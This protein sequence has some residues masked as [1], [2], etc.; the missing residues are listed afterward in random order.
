MTAPRVE[1]EDATSQF[2]TAEV[3]LKCWGRLLK[4]SPTLGWPQ[5]MSLQDDRSLVCFLLYLCSPRAR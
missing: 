3:T 1:R 4:R 2:Y 5:R